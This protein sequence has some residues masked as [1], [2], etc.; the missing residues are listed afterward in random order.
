MTALEAIAWTGV[1]ML[2]GISTFVVV[3][4]ILGIIVMFILFWRWLHK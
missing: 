1:V 4:A 2:G 3:A